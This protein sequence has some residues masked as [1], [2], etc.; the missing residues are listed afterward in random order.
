MNTQNIF[1]MEPCKLIFSVDFVCLFRGRENNYV[2]VL[3]CTE[4]DILCKC[5]L[6]ANIWLLGA[7]FRAW[8]RARWWL[9]VALKE[10]EHGGS[11]SPEE[12][13]FTCALPSCLTTWL[14]ETASFHQSQWDSFKLFL[15]SAL[16][17]ALYTAQCRVLQW[18]H[19]RN[20]MMS[21]Y[22]PPNCVSWSWNKFELSYYGA[23][24]L[25][26]GFWEHSNASNGI[27]S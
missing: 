7:F 3:K 27:F 5:G 25:I 11:Q 21:M 2:Q 1:H 12:T 16:L 24:D 19:H 26:I 20:D 18:S 22:W 6:S 14:M 9:A 15:S 13:F 17:W 4:T 8:S 10:E 23:S